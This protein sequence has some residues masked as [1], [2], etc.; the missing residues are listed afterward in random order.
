M[1]RHGVLHMRIY[2]LG[3]RLKYCAAHG[4]AAKM[5]LVDFG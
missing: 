2:Q 4:R 3:R 5:D 1:W